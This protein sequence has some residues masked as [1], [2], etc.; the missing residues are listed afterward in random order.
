[1]AGGA[2]ASNAS[3]SSQSALFKTEEFT[4]MVDGLILELA[5]D[6]SEMGKTFKGLAPDTVTVCLH[7]CCVYWMS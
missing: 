1:M 5:D 7:T 6:D 3:A 2:N 4:P